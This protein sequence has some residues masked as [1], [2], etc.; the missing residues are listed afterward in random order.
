[1][2]EIC[3]EVFAEKQQSRRKISTSKARIE[4]H[5]KATKRQISLFSNFTPAVG[6]NFISILRGVLNTKH[7]FTAFLCLEFESLFRRR[8]ILAKK[9]LI[10]SCQ[11][12]QLSSLNRKAQLL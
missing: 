7:L 6:V 5:P 8:N 1:V 3:E 12:H 4:A 2:D 11:F 9:L 10:K